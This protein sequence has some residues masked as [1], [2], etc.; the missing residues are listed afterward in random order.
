MTDMMF[1][2]E[3]VQLPPVAERR[4]KGR[5][6]ALKG[7]L[8]VHS[9]GRFSFPCTIRNLSDNGARIAFK[10]GQMMPSD[11]YLVDTWA[12]RGHH[13]RIAWVT[14]TE[15][16]LSFS[17]SFDMNAITDPAL[18]YLKRFWDQRMV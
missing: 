13:A 17:N 10:K 7:A 9:G 3:P 11:F 12:A 14:A 16:G 2:R 1:Q 5:R 6:R 15:A 8:V 4:P 18:G